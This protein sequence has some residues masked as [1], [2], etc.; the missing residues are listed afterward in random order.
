MC[1]GGEEGRRGV[2]VRMEVCAVDNTKTHYQAFFWVLID[3]I[4]EHVVLIITLFD[5]QTDN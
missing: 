4:V 1:V 3:L 2:T 5:N